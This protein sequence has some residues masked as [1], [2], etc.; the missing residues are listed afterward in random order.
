MLAL[1]NTQKRLQRLH[2]KLQEDET[3]GVDTQAA[4]NVEMDYDEFL[5]KAGFDMA[6]ASP[7]S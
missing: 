1:R 4:L 5:K 6:T 7:T 3:V 2:D